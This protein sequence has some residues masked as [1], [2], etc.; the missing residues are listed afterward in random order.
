MGFIFIGAPELVLLCSSMLILPAIWC[1][2]LSLLVSLNAAATAAAAAAAGAE[3]LIGVFLTLLLGRGRP[4]PAGF[5]IMLY[6]RET[7][8]QVGNARGEIESARAPAAT[9][10]APRAHLAGAGAHKRKHT[11]TST[12][13]SD[14]AEP[15]ERAASG[16]T[17]SCGSRISLIGFSLSLSLSLWLALPD[18]RYAA[19]KKQK[20]EATC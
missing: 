15:C 3:V 12:Q 20:H 14:R 6:S 10:A 2:L 19:R 1:G 8:K 18:W 16:L 4:P 11:D 17:I 7:H 5:L 9:A 13:V